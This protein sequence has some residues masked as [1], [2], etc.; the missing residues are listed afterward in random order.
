MQKKGKKAVK[1]KSKENSEKK[2]EK[3]ILDLFGTEILE[4][5]VSK[6]GTGAHVLIPKEHL[7]KKIKIII[8][9]DKDE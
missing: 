1:N 4:R 7:G 5:N 6:F 9:E 3:I 2:S 8:E